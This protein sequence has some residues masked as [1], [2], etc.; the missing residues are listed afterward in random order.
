MLKLSKKEDYSIVFL[1]ELVA[2]YKKRV[3]SISEVS[4]KYT[5]SPLFLRN[6][7]IELKKSSFIKAKE[8]KNGGYFLA[9]NP[10]KIKLGQIL[11]VLSKPILDCCALTG[12]QIKNDCPNKSLCKPGFVWKKLNKEFLDKVSDLNL[13]E[14][15]NYK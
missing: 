11:N 4:K 8:G 3:T 7:V 12:A 1:S 5:I 10:S 6:L 14:F 13:V 15:F 9:N 2:N